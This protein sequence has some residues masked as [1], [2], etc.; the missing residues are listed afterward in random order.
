MYVHA[1]NSVGA[2]FA[3]NQPPPHQARAKNT[4]KDWKNA[5]LIV[6]DPQDS[7]ADAAKLMRRHH[8]GTVVVAA[9]KDG[10]RKPIGI[11]TD[12]DIAIE[13]VAEEVALESVNVADVM[14]ENL[15]CIAADEGVMEALQLMKERA[16]R[17]AGRGAVPAPPLARARQARRRRR[18]RRRAARRGARGAWRA[19]RAPAGQRA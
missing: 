3:P 1:T 4:L 2:S 8:V 11:L 9:E 14:S 7:I 13:I 15:V 17:R 12:R 5:A 10:D 19:A 16:V 18:R 6:V